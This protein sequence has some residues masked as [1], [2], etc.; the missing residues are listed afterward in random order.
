MTLSWDDDPYL[1]SAFGWT[2]D[3]PGLDREAAERLA[4]EIDRRFPEVTGG[5]MPRVSDPRSSCHTFLHRR[6]VACV[7]E[8]LRRAG[9]RHSESLVA[10]IEAWIDKVAV[11]APKLDQPEFRIGLRY[12]SVTVPGDDSLAAAHCLAS[13]ADVELSNLRPRLIDPTEW[14]MIWG[15][16]STMT[17][18]RRGLEELST[19]GLASAMLSEIRA[20]DEWVGAGGAS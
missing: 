13:V 7:A 10:D 6:A 5:R 12:W 9:D 11:E 19:S 8:G 1:R 18:I 4:H 3:V 14:F 20:W 15:D 16:A 2:V 17:L